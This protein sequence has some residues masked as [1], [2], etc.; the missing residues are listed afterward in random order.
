MM[1]FVTQTSEV[2][3]EVVAGGACVP[4][5]STTQ[6]MGSSEYMLSG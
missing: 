1:C 6:G 2:V 3:A 4:G 5:S